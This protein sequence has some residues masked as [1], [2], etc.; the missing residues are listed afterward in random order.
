LGD[1][2]PSGKF[3]KVANICFF[4]FADGKLLKQKG[5]WD[6]LSFMQQIKG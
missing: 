3:V 6:T 4:R 5:L 1:L 2:P